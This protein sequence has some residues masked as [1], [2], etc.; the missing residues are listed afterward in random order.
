M[1]V[2][3]SWKPGESITAERLNRVQAEA[4]RPRRDIVLGN[5]SS[6]VYEA[7][8]NQAAN[9][10]VPA[11]KLMIAIEDFS[12]PEGRTDLSYGPDD[13]PSGLCK[14]MRLSRYDSTHREDSGPTTE[15]V[16]DA[17]GGLNNGPLRQCGE[18]FYVVFNADS[19]RWEVLQNLSIRLVP[20]IVRECLP[21]GW[22]LIELSDW[23]GRPTSESVSDSAS[24]SGSISESVS[25]A[26]G[27][28]DV[29]ENVVADG[30]CEDMQ[31]VSVDRTTGEGT[32]EYVYAHTTRL[33][34]MMIGGLIKM[35]KKTVPSTSSC[36]SDSASASLSAS[37][38]ASDEDLT[39]RLYDVV[40]GVWPLLAM[41]FPKFECCEDPVTGA[42]EVRMVQCNRAVVEG[43]ECIGEEDPCPE[44]SVSASES[45]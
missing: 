2:P 15:R 14:M 33:M 36:E 42:T 30:T 19:K 38:S 23:D 8:G 25:D 11:L 43:Y 16:W 41:P 4:I 31:S 45:V 3:R 20:G 22:H 10:R 29:C 18:V 34:P 28:C 27:A 40:D 1:T 24:T 5:G 13:V 9:M 12:I 32:G 7:L 26:A 37:L 6:M 21:D 17:I 44:G 35:L 39:D